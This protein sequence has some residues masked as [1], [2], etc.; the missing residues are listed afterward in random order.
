MD[1]DSDW[2]KNGNSVSLTHVTDSYD[3]SGYQVTGRSS[4]WMGILQEFNADRVL[5]ANLG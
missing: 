1:S 5:S 2:T 3:G 4:T